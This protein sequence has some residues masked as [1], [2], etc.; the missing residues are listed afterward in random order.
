MKLFILSIAF[1]SS[2]Q[3]SSSLQLHGF[4]AKRVLEELSTQFTSTDSP[5]Q[6]S[7]YS[8]CITYVEQNVKNCS[9]HICRIDGGLSLSFNLTAKV[10]SIWVTLDGK[11]TMDMT[12][13][14]FSS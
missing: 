12:G 1:I 11:V 10:S 4:D 3:I 9:Y 7:C 13:L 2:V 8:F 6:P 5:L 14:T